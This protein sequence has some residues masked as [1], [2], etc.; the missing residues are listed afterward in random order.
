MNMPTV[1]LFHLSLTIALA[2]FSLF[3]S[4]FF[5]AWDDAFSPIPCLCYTSCDYEFVQIN[6]FI[7]LPMMSFYSS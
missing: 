4:S 6:R 2:F 5:I 3:K 7:L 1:H